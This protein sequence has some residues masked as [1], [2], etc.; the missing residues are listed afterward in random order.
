[1]AC[2]KFSTRRPFSFFMHTI[3]YYVSLK[4]DPSHTSRRIAISAAHQKLS[5]LC[6]FPSTTMSLFDLFAG[7]CEGD[8]KDED[9]EQ[10]DNVPTDENSYD[11]N[12]DLDGDPTSKMASKPVF[13]DDNDNNEE[14]EDDGPMGE[15]IFDNSDSD[16]V[17]D[18]TTK[19]ASKP[20]IEDDKDKEDG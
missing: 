13:E 12:S 18:S 6:T 19:K 11:S 3:V 1:M 4:T 17:G 2:W 20:V 16:L 15:N 14:Q 7:E 8:G 5:T 9:E 10:E